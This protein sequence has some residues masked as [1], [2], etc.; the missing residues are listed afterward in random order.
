MRY[1]NYKN[2]IFDYLGIVG[3]EDSYTNLLKALFENVPEY[4]Q[5]LLETLFNEN[6]FSLDDFYFETRRKYFYQSHYEIP[7]II[8]V[9]NKGDH[10]ALIEV[11]VFADEGYGQ[12]QRYY[13]MFSNK[14][15]EIYYADTSTIL[16]ENTNKKFY[17]LT[18]YDS[19][20]QNE[21]FE[22]IKWEK[23][24][25]PLRDIVIENKY[26][27]ALARSLINKV[28]S[29]KVKENLSADMLW[30]ESMGYGWAKEQN[31]FAVLKTYCFN[32]AKWTDEHQWN[33]FNKDSN[34]YELK[35]SFGKET[36]EGIHISEF[37]IDNINDSDLDKCYQFHYEIAYNPGTKKVTIRLDYHLHP[38]LSTQEINNFSKE[39]IE[40]K[41]AKDIKYNKFKDL[42]EKDIDKI[43]K[44]IK[45]AN[46]RRKEIA[47]N[48]KNAISAESEKIFS[49]KITTRAGNNPMVL[50]KIENIETTGKNINDIVEEINKFVDC[51]E[52][53]IDD[54]VT[55][56][57]KPE[58]QIK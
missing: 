6:D 40:K 20:P 24:V 11:K 52:K 43:Q 25:E 31:L 10:F 14:E 51:T 55:P 1:E 15:K 45:K 5:K 32:N 21:N 26:L 22:N 49:K 50:A 13:N 54:F 48:I 36:W 16:N 18:I 37:T 34:A 27:S 3:R 41:C 46:N 30:T 12:T 23:I 38:Y 2:D 17:F 7:D 58:K 9:D 28:D 39:I 19:E 42:N 29:T 56:Y 44:S 35:C 53:V 8:I 33:G 4:K 57:T 47:N